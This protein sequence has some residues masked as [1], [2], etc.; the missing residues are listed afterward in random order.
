MLAAQNLFTRKRDST[1]SHGEIPE[2]LSHVSFYCY[3]DM[4]GRQTDRQTDRITIASTC[5]A[6]LAEHY[7]RSCVKTT[8][9][10]SSRSNSY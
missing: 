3:R 5:L 7:V 9:P 2:T 6:L 4:M 8:P 10:S 1:L